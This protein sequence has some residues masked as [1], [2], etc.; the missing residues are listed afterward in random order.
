MYK[1]ISNPDDS[2]SLEYGD[3]NVRISAQSWREAADSAHVLAHAIDDKNNLAMA[4]LDIKLIRDGL[5]NI[6]KALEQ[7]ECELNAYSV[8]KR[9]IK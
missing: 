2:V 4:R 3:I 1:L 6:N 5:A 7:I 8:A 9:M